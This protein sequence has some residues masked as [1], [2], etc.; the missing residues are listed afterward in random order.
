MLRQ[1]KFLLKLSHCWM[2]DGTKQSS[3][4]HVHFCEAKLV[5]MEQKQPDI[6]FTKADMYTYR[7]RYFV[8]EKHV[9]GR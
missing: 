2:V 7:L 1:I 3:T 8:V 4:H 5:C 9:K 6:K